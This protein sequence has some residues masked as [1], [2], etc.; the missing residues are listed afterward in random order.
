MEPR[1]QVVNRA[2]ATELANAVKLLHVT[3]KSPAAAASKRETLPSL[4]DLGLDL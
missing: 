4:A 1:S 2:E 3:G